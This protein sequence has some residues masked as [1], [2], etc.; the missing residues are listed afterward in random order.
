MPVNEIDVHSQDGQVVRKM[1]IPV[2]LSNNYNPSIVY[3]VVVGYQSNKRQGNASTKT[4]AERRGG[5][6]KPWR[7]KGTG[8]ARS[9]STRNPIWRHGGVTFGPKPRD[10]RVKLP[11]AKKHKALAYLLAARF[12]AGT[13][14]ILDS[15]E[16]NSPRTCFAQTLVNRFCGK[17][18]K[19]IVVV[20]GKSNTIILAFRNIEHCHLLEA[21][22]L[23]AYDVLQADHIIIT[24]DAFKLVMARLSRGNPRL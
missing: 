13:V 3:E 21:K 19:T 24:Q 8:R 4:R 9:G 15:I 16:F 6:R 20:S 22:D 14:H 11:D 18:Q 2:V 17:G 1:E 10:W 5:G 12:K 7:Q 23:N